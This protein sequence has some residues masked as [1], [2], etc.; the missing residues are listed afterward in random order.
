MPFVPVKCTACGGE[1]QLD[2]HNESG[3]CVYCGSKV[4][5]KEAVQ[6]MELSGSVTVQ[7]IATLEKLLQNAETFHKLGD[8]YKESQILKQV[9]EDYPEDYRGWWRLALPYISDPL[10]Y[11]QDYQKNHQPYDENYW[12]ERKFNLASGSVHTPSY[13]AYNNTIYY[14]L[15]HIRNAIK[16]AQPKEVL[17]MKH[18]AG[19]WFKR[20]LQSCQNEREKLIN[21]N[22]IWQKAYEVKERA[23][24]AFE[25]PFN[26]L[27]MHGG[28][29][30]VERWRNITCRGI[31]IR[32]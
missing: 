31:L 28:D 23:L 2:D 16:L 1:I 29:Q 5:F 9:T 26:G 11:Y 3:F 22:E 27:E 25:N 19:E 13:Q 12:G 6:K 20:Y 18:K 8:Y 10:E 21:P 32:N 30:M 17:E 15:G 4:L 7:G 14:Y 24:N